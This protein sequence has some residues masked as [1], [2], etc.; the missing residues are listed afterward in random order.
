MLTA[1]I[2]AG[3]LEVGEGVPKGLSH[4]QIAQREKENL[5]RIHTL[6]SYQVIMPKYIQSAVSSAEIAT[7]GARFRTLIQILGNINGEVGLVY[8]SATP[9]SINL[10]FFTENNWFKWETAN[11]FKKLSDVI[12]K[13]WKLPYWEEYKIKRSENKRQRRSTS[14]VKASQLR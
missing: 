8:Y 4:C 3:T 7:I 5:C 12:I 14:F 9:Y 2:N 13:E 6:Y 11:S 10:F 1:R